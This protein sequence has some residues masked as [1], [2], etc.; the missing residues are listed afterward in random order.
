[1]NLVAAFPSG[2]G[3]TNLAL[4]TPPLPE[5]QIHCIG[6]DITWMKFGQDGI[7]RGLNPEFGFFG[8]APGTNQQTNPTAMEM[9]NKNTIFT[10]VAETSDGG[11]YWQAMEDEVDPVSQLF[12]FLFRLFF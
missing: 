8:I 1:M 4:L 10:N 5:Y 11:Y 2:C 3:K 6:D 7:L 12:H 9:V